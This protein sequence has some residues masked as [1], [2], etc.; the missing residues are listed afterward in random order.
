MKRQGPRPP[1]PGVGPGGRTALGVAREAVAG[2]GGRRKGCRIRHGYGA[3]TLVW[4]VRRGARREAAAGA[5]TA[6]GWV[7]AR[8]TGGRPATDPTFAASWGIYDLV[9]GSWNEAFVD[10]L[11]LPARLLPPVRPAGEALG[12]LSGEA[13]RATGLPAGLPVFNPVGDTQASFLGSVPE[14]AGTALVNLGTG[15]QVCW[16]VPAFEPPGER[17]EK[18]PLPGRGRPLYPS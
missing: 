8:L 16:A 12:G 3:A 11:G 9:R 18:R 15:G 7:A 5:C 2:L 13:A 17:V 1:G 14:V 10:R 4:L 6:A